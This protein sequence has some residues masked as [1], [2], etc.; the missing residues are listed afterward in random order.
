MKNLGIWLIAAGI[1]AIVGGFLFDPT[2]PDYSN[3]DAVSS[4]AA[5]ML[6][7]GKLSVKVAAMFLGSVTAICGSVFTAA[8]WATEVLIRTNGTASADESARA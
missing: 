1:C 3:V 5:R 6:D 4:I 2:V 7:P 8:G